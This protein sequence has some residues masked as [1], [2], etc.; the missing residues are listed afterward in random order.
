MYCQE[1]IQ[2]EMKKILIKLNDKNCNNK[3]KKKY[4]EQLI[5]L[6]ESFYY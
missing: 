4:K 1:T 5:L 3:Q 6:R 2:L